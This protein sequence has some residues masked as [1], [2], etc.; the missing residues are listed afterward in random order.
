MG[1]GLITIQWW[2]QTICIE[3]VLKA[4]LTHRNSILLGNAMGLVHLQWGQ[5]KAWQDD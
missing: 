1:N 4:L 2:Y 3:T 5:R